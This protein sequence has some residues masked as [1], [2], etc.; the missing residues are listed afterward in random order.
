MKVI[1]LKDDIYRTHIYFVN[2]CTEEEFVAHVKKKYGVEYEVVGTAGRTSH[3]KSENG[4]TVLFWIRTIDCKCCTLIDSL[5]TARHEI[6]HVTVAAL[7][8]AGIP[9]SPENEEVIA[10]FSDTIFYQVIK[11]LRIKVT[12][13]PKGKGY[14]KAKKKK[15]K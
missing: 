1:R 4:A 6:D 13:M 8:I 15:K 2:E 3:L 9:Y 5:V 7:K 11:H 12:S 14:P 10:Y